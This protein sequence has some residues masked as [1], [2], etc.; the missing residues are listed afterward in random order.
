MADIDP[1]TPILVGVGQIVQHWD[2]TDAAN[3]P[4]PLGLQVAAAHRALADSEAAGALA[5]LVDRVVVVRSNL[6]SIP[7][8]RHPFGRCENPPRTLAA[9]LDMGAARCMYSV[10]GGDQ[11]QALVNEAARSEEHTS[12]LQSL[13][14]ISYAVFCL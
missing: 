3:A 13:M 6:D 5:A 7:G 8:T 11:P 4:S 10:V 12:E 14:R 2:G 1:R 9:E